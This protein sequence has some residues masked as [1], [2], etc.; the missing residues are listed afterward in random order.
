[1][2]Y[3]ALE[4]A[5]ADADPMGEMMR[6]VYIQIYISVAITVVTTFYF[7][8]FNVFSARLAY[9]VRSMYFKRCLEQDAA[10]Y[11]EH[12]ATEMPSKIANETSKIK[13]GFGIKTG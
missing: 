6:F 3:A 7:Y 1:V 13:N 11:D 9:K 4:A 12:S 5:Y 2:D 10:F 8:S